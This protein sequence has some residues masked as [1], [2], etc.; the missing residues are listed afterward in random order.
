MVHI[1]QFG[2]A[3][4]IGFHVAHVTFVPRGCIRSGVR[5]V[6][7]IEMRTCGSEICSTAIAKFVNMKTVLTRREAPDLCMHPHT[8]GD[9]RECDDAA[10]FV[11]CGRLQHRD[12]F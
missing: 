3:G 7:G 4:S 10:D 12:T 11:A 2:V 1:I 9:R 6:G 5:L 8:I